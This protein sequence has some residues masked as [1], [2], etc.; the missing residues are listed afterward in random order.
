MSGIKDVEMALVE[1]FRSLPLEGQLQTLAYTE[2]LSQ[3]FNVQTSD[4]ATTLRQ[5]LALSRSE[6]NEFL[7]RCIPGIV[8]DFEEYPE[9]REFS[10]LDGLDWEP[11]DD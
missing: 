3:E 2:T 10:M 4:R 5:I 7:T 1:R 6:R 9:L 11:G 8:A